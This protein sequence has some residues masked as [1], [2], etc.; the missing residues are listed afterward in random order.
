MVSSPITGGILNLNLDDILHGSIAPPHFFHH[1]DMRI[2]LVPWRSL[3]PLPHLPSSQNI[4]IITRLPIVSVSRSTQMFCR[5]PGL[6]G[7]APNTQRI[8]SVNGDFYA[9]D[10]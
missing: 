9:S 1:R 6:L 3:L 5:L 10:G 2:D 4:S 7:L 8:P